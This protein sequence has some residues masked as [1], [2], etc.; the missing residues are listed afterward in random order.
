MKM[1]REASP[2]LQNQI[3]HHQ[4]TLK[5]STGQI[6]ILELA[7]HFLFTKWLVSD[8]QDQY[9]LTIQETN[10]SA[11][12]L[13]PTSAEPTHACKQTTHMEEARSSANYAKQSLRFY[14]DKNSSEETKKKKRKK[15]LGI[16]APDPTA[17]QAD[18]HTLITNSSTQ[19]RTE[20]NKEIDC[21]HPIHFP[22]EGIPDFNGINLGTLA[23]II[24]NP[25]L[26]PLLRHPQQL[27]RC[28]RTSQTV[29]VFAEGLSVYK[30]FYPYFWENNKC[31]RG[32]KS[33]L[34]QRS[35]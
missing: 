9:Q 31:V 29:N 22:R 27:K 18:T 25:V 17:L 19:I 26:K 10:T 30:C 4:R 20:L 2:Q 12:H 5:L 11:L 7:N 6:K 14:P 3:Y 21:A 13:S 33:L 35:L 32:S 28:S 8:I 1:E 34:W 15:K 24:K 16:L 23:R